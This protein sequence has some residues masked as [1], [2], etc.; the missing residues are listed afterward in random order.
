MARA[1]R[2]LAQHQGFVHFLTAMRMQRESL[3]RSLLNEEKEVGKWKE[4]IRLCDAMLAIPERMVT[5]GRE[6]G[7]LLAKLGKV[8]DE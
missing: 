7:L 3:V 6:S 1:Y 5:D 4:A 8:R 2:E